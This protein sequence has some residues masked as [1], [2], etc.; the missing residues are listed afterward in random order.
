MEQSIEQFKGQTRLPKFAIPKRYDLHLKLDLSACTFSGTVLIDLSI[1]EETKF[2]VLNA[3]ELAVHKVWF[4]N[5]SNPELRPSGVVLDH[6]DEL[7]VL[8][9][10][11]E[12]RVGEGI[13]GIEF[14]A[15]L[16]EYLKGFYKCTY[17]DG[18]EKKNM[19]VTQF[20]AV[21]ARRSFPCWDEPALKAT[22]KITLDVP[23]ELMALS[24]M[25]I[26]DEKLIGNTKTVYFEESPIM[27]TYIVGVVV[28]LF[29]YVEQTAAD[30]VKVRVY[31]PV[32]KSDKGQFALDV[33]VKSLDLFSKYF[34]VPYSLP[35]LDLVAV[36]EFSGGAMENY[37]L[38]IYRENELLYD[39]LQ[40][41][42]ARKQR[43]TIV[44]AHEVAHQWFGNL[45]TMEWWTDLWL[46]E[47][48]A[49]W[50]SY[51]ATDI[52]FP[53]WKIWTQFLDYYSTGLRMDAQEQSHPIQV[54]IPHPRFLEEIFDAICYNKGSALIRMLQ[55]YIGDE[56]FQKSLSSYVKRYAGKNAKTEDLWSVLSEESGIKVKSMMDA[57]TTKQGY[58]V[59]SVK[60]KG[61][62]LQFEQS[63]FQL[64]GLEG[65]VEWIVPITLAVGSYDKRKNFLLETKFGEVDISDLV[66]SFDGDS[67]SS[68]EKSEEKSDE[69]LWIKVNIEQGGFYRVNYDQNL[70]ARLRK[71]VETNCLSALD[72][73]GI[74]DDSYALCMSGKQSLSSLLSLINVYQKELDYVVLSKL[75]KVCYDVVE[76]AKEA[77]PDLANELKQL[78]INGLLHSAEN[79]GWESKPGESHSNALLR[80]EV[81]MALATFGHEKTQEEALQRF[82]S[83][84]HDGNTA[85]LSADTR[86]AVYIAVMRNSST[87]NRK[88]FES[89]LAIYRDAN[90]VMQV[91]EQILRWLASSPD[92]DIVVEALNFV[93]SEE[94]R[95]QD[96]IYGLSGIS[97]ECRDVAWK[98]LT[99]KWELI[100][101]KYGAGMLLTNFI[102]SIVA[103]LSSHEKG[104][105]VEAFFSNRS[106]QAIAL[107]L[108][109]GI[110]QIR[111]KARW[112]SNMREE[113]QTAQ[114]VVQQLLPKN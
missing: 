54:E 85:P 73:F 6:D 53:E 9:F 83:S 101:S 33:A 93:V 4:A 102:N 60:A 68:K 111:I 8:V 113:Q 99:E 82:Q 87:S 96:I 42:T 69:K 32:G 48:F 63:Q 103:P 20:E 21:D 29:D 19:A 3:L 90:T 22:F 14:S 67:S 46:N 110:G 107:T 105:E 15:V 64:S 86:E 91:K 38:I 106:Y 80:R 66:N 12:L 43:N 81:L 71:A 31:C 98:W 62:I 84:L 109:R 41:T 10:E 108:K 47:G 112:V 7:L 30:G 23:V 36:P 39:P 17:L 44:A 35:K 13:L 89:L 49:T 45:V 25:P 40:S 1:V 74:L 59:I 70:E 27:S 58:P 100:F 65:D 56:I 95:D 26:I 34:S 24:N 2:L 79:L 94:V 114:Q 28:G 16:N 78:F 77:I 76:I 55:S 75:I 5:S 92:P 104:D 37:G 18:E 97:S 61:S 52:L 51:L 88:G 72:K 50:I 57:W 11:E